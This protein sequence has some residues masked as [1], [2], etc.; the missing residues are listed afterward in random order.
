MT[1]T[2]SSWNVNGIRACSQKEG[3][4]WFTNTDYDIIGFQET[5]ADES[6]LD[7]SIRIKDGYD[8]FFCSSTVKKGYSGTAV[9]TKIK[10]LSVEFELPYEEFKGEG[11]IVHLEF[12]KFH[13]FNGYFPNGGAAILDESGKPTGEFKRVPY[14]MA[15]F[16]AFFEYAQKL[17]LDKPIVVCGD[18]NIAHR[19]ID[20]A[21]PKTN[22][23]NT[24]FLPN[25]RAFLDKLVNNGYIDTFRFVNGDVKDVYSWWSYKSFARPKNIGWRIDYFFVSDELK[26]CI[27]DARVETT[28]T[29]SDHCP[30]TLVLDL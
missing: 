11:R 14:K 12:E 25:E 30:V 23:K 9:F 17:R 7:D 15:F 29:G 8:S 20:L 26:D 13:F 27:K 2:L 16:D 21:R 3:F 4:S 18:F 1:I 5:K 22:M 19:E 28:V 10:P 6:Q 24:G